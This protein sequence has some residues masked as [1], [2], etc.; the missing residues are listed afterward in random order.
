MHYLADN[1]SGQLGLGPAGDILRSHVQYIFGTEEDRRA[2]Y[3]SGLLSHTLVRGCPWSRVL[4]TYTS[5]FVYVSQWPSGFTKPPLPLWQR[6]SLGLERRDFCFQ[7]R[8]VAVSSESIGSC[9]SG[10]SMKWSEKMGEVREGLDAGKQ[11]LVKVTFQ[12]QCGSSILFDYRVRENWL[13]YE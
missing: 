2:V 12:K 1:S 4:F 13:K 7:R 11:F 3:S 9:S 10:Q 6:K 5:G 8:Q